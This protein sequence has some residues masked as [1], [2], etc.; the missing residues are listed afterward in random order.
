MLV[1]AGL[2]RT[3]DLIVLGQRG[4]AYAEPALMCPEIDAVVTQLVGVTYHASIGQATVEAARR[5]YERLASQ[6]ID[7]SAYNTTASAADLADLR[8][9]LGISEWNV[10]GVSYGT[11]LALTYV[12]EHPEGIRTVTLDSVMPPH[13]AG[14]GLNWTNAGV[15]LDRIFHA[16]AADRA[17]AA[18]Y[19]DVAA[20]FA[21]LVTQ[22]E[23]EPLRGHV[24]PVLLPGQVPASDTEPVEVVVDGGSL[25]NWVV[26]L[27]DVLGPDLPRLLHE[28]T[29]GRPEPVMASIAAV[30]SQPGNLSWGLHYGVVCSEWV[31]YEPT[32]NTL[33]Q[34]RRAFP[35]FPASVL[36]QAPLYPYAAD[37]C[38]VW[39]VAPAPPT[40]RTLPTSAIPTLVVA[41][42]YDAITSAETAE[43]TA[44]S[45]TSAT[46]ITI[47]GAG[48]RVVPRSPCAQAVMASFLATPDAPDTR[49]AAD[50]TPPTFNT[51]AP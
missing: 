34:G 10:F 39:P 12:R 46:A 47:A 43:T 23:A 32:D 4:S 5:C 33:V 36:A 2:N 22:L 17:C 24:V 9:V 14:L 15:V 51:A 8:G 40:Q 13:L 27:T 3:R 49:C 1:D 29:N 25:V 44:R 11:D 45:L 48:H 19:P 26:G 30:F 31:P 37:V 16:C 41:G 6:G 38:A 50:R 42:E 35:T 20:T 28:I 7:L 21:R 18:G